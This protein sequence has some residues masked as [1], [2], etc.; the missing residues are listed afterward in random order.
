MKWACAAI[1]LGW[2]ASMV[3][4]WAWGGE[5]LGHYLTLGVVGFTL[6]LGL[7]MSALTKERR[8][9]KPKEI[10]P[11]IWFLLAALV[12]ALFYS[13]LER[14]VQG[15]LTHVPMLPMYIVMFLDFL[16][17]G[18]YVWWGKLKGRKKRGGQ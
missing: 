14:T 15:E 5:G 18:A 12:F 17:S 1:G 9:G 2:A 4:E 7:F 8:A 11:M 3:Y 13:A 16:G 10:R 6:A